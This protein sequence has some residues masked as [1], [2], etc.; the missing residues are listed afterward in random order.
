MKV[1]NKISGE[2]ESG[3]LKESTKTHQKLGFRWS[4]I[5]DG[6]KGRRK[7]FY[8]LKDFLDKFDEVEDLET[9]IL[10]NKI[11]KSFK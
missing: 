10:R 5:L 1:F 6:Q 9:V 3:I 4:F 11:I 2:I 7:L 8:T